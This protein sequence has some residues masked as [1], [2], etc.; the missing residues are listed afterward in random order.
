MGISFS[1]ALSPY[2]FENSWE[3]VQTHETIWYENRVAQIDSEGINDRC[4]IISTE[5]TERKRME[6]QLV[7]ARA[8]P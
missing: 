4:M 7:R 2:S 5:I 8:R 3:N 6:A 1:G